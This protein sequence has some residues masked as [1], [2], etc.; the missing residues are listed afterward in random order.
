[1][2]T[3]NKPK[4]QNDE[5][6]IEELYSHFKSTKSQTRRRKRESED[7]PMNMRARETVRVLIFCNMTER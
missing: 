1:M 5:P 7:T 6:L 2:K 3:N 4:Q